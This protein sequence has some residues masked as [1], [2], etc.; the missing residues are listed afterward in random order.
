M[1][2]AAIVSFE[3]SKARLSLGVHTPDLGWDSDTERLEVNDDFTI[4]Q[5]IGRNKLELSP[6]A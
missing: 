4:K 3:F 1:Q 6:P 5:R 2:L